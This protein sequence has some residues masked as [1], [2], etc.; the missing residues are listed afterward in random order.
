MNTVSNT[1]SQFYQ[2]SVWRTC[3]TFVF[4]K[5]TFTIDWMGASLQIICKE[6]KIGIVTIVWFQILGDSQLITSKEQR[7]LLVQSIQTQARIYYGSISY[8]PL[9]LQRGCS[10]VIISYPIPFYKANP[11][12]YQQSFYKTYEIISQQLLSYGLTPSIKYNLPESTIVIDLGQSINNLLHECGKNTKEKIKKAEIVISKNHL[13]FRKSNNQEDFESFYKTY[14]Q[15]ASTKGFGAIT[16][17]MWQNIIK[18]AITHNNI[19]H[20]YGIYDQAGYCI[21]GALCI[22]NNL[23]LIYLYGA[24]DRRFGNSGLSQ[25][26][27]RK[28]IQ[29]AQEAG[30]RYYDLLGASRIGAHNDWLAHVTQF[31]LGFGGTKYEFVGSFDYPVSW[32][33]RIYLYSMKIMSAF[34]K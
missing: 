20:L 6:K 9:Y 8:I 25:R 2:S 19:F 12:E 16:P 7:M 3:N 34:K 14:T 27:H 15:T 23:G 18:K 13:I 22:S 1:I 33:G 5:P 28:I 29:S 17:N 26:L 30:F 10:H 24:N 4:Q 21:S 11:I 31:K 32:I